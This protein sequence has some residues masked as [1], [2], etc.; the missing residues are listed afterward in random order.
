[1]N[2]FNEVIKGIDNEIHQEKFREILNWVDTHY[3]QLDKSI[4]WSQPLYSNE[5]TFIISLTPFKGHIAVNLE[6]GGI[7]HFREKLDKTEYSYTEMT[8]RI[9][10]N[11]P[12]DYAL[13]KEMIELQLKEKDGYKTFWRKA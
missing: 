12:I 4:K 3:P 10:W 7:N 9:K 8:V 1:M 2:P 5:G 13:L 11:Q 6:K